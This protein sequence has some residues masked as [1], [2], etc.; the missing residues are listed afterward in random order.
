MEEQKSVGNSISRYFLNPRVFTL[1][2]WIMDILKDK[3][4][5]HDDIIERI[6]STSLV[7]DKDLQAF[8]QLILQ[9][10]ECAYVKAVGDYKKEAEKFGLKINIVDQ[11]IS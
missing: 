8:G 3:Y 10:Y 4:A 9:V 2:K 7:T 5:P 11:P 6:A 1:K